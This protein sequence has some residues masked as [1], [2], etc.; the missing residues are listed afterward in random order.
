MKFL[1]QSNL[2]PKTKGKKRVGRNE[3]FI[4]IQSKRQNDIG[5]FKRNTVFN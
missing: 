3:R 1:D 4:Q 5:H 2:I